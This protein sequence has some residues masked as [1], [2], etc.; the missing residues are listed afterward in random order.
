[1]L[2]YQ[3]VFL[4][5]LIL[6]TSRYKGW[7]AGYQLGYEINSAKMTANDIG[8]GYTGSDFTVHSSW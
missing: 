2:L 6:L 7:Y 8:I 5:I 4:D 3:V 1:M